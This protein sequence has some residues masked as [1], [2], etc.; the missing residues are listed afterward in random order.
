MNQSVASRCI[1]RTTA[2]VLVV[3]GGGGGRAYVV[4]GVDLGALLEQI[5]DQHQGAVLD[6]TVKRILSDGVLCD[7]R[8]TLGQEYL[9]TI[10]VTCT[11][12]DMQRRI[13][14]LSSERERECV[15]ERES[16]IRSHHRGT[17]TA[18]Y[19]WLGFIG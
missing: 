12:S 9:G 7:D 6:S 5:L 1:E 18:T 13:E 16:K 17:R 10:E 2:R 19:R 8:R 4:D 14:S 3:G 15:S 11:T